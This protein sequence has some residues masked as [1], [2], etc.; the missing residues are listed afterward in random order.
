[1]FFSPDISLLLSPTYAKRQYCFLLCVPVSSGKGVDKRARIVDTAIMLTSKAQSDS[2]R[3]RP[4][5][6]DFNGLRSSAVECILSILSSG[7]KHLGRPVAHWCQQPVHSAAFGGA[8]S[9]RPFLTIR[10]SSFLK[11]R[12]Q[13]GF[14]PPNGPRPC[15]GAL[16]LG[17]VRPIGM[18]GCGARSC[19]GAVAVAGWPPPDLKD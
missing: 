19:T 17:G 14:C 12:L 9:E 8:P 18:C 7:F 1:M 5:R 3:T 6:V 2:A 4:W 15:S 10:G 16:V 11:A 13:P